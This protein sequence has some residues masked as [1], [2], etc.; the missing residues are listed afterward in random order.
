L[1]LARART[2]RSSSGAHA[3]YILNVMI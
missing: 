3:N 1:K 2:R